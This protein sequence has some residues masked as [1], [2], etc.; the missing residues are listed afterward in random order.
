DIAISPAL[1][2]VATAGD[3]CIRVHDLTDF[4]D[5]WAIVQLEDERGQL[6][7]LGWSEDGQFLTVSTKT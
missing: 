4:Q 7:K 6:D 2:K 5:V 1:N 3:G